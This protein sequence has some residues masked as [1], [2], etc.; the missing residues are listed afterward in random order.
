MRIETSQNKTYAVNWIDTSITNQNMLLAQF[1]DSRRLP[2]IAAEFD[3]LTEVRRYDENQGDKT[4]EGYSMLACVTR[5]GN[6][7]LIRM[8]RVTS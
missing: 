8:E 2:E 5:I 3:G 7:V 1:E 4:Y 6:E